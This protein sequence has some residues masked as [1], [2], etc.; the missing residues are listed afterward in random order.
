MGRAVGAACRGAGLADDAAKAQI[1]ISERQ[2]GRKIGKHAADF[3]LDPS[4]P[5][6][7]AQLRHLVAQ[8]VASPHRVIEGTFRGQGVV[9]FF[10]KGED[11]VVTTPANEFVT[12][13]KRG[14]DN[15]AVRRVVGK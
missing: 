6:H 8:I 13:L 4:N 15:P 2:F 12:I 14:I 1:T 9:K 11:V 7:R 10:I 3:G 5:V